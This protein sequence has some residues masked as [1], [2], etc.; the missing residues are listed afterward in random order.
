MTF[1]TNDP[2]PIST[3]SRDAYLL[4]G[5]GWL[6]QLPGWF[7]Y[8]FLMLQAMG[9]LVAQA[10]PLTANRFEHRKRFWSETRV[11]SLTVVITLTGIGSAASELMWLPAEA[12]TASDLTNVSYVLSEE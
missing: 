2:P 6:A 10:H 12:V 9:L 4:G 8:A 3:T 1:K 5:I 11:V 7:F